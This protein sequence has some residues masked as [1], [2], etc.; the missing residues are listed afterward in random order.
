MKGRCLHN[1]HYILMYWN[2]FG[3]VAKGV[4]NKIE[5][6]HMNPLVTCRFCY[7][8][9]DGEVQYRP[10]DGN[11]YCN[12][13]CYTLFKHSEVYIIPSYPKEE[14][15]QQPELPWDSLGGLNL[16]KSVMLVVL[17]A[18]AHLVKCYAL[19][20][21]FSRNVYFGGLE[22]QL[23]SA[24]IAMTVSRDWFHLGRNY[25]WVSITSW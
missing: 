1:P 2:P 10:G 21:I 20:T 8:V 6:Q 9:L 25:Q 23:K 24:V 14:K 18:V 17:S 19:G 12:E 4:N 3:L 15:P 11:C 13:Q 22:Q 7:S 5:R 16:W